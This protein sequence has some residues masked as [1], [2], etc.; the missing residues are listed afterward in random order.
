MKVITLIQRRPDITRA[1]FK[2]YYEKNHA[3]LGT[4]YFPFEKYVRN[5]L[6]S[7]VPDDVGFDVLMECW[8]DRATAV[9]S[10]TGDVGDIFN[11]DEARFMNAPPRPEG[12]DV[13]EHLVAGPPRGVDARGARKVA[14]F[15]AAGDELGHGDFLAAATNWGRQLAA[16]TGATRA[17]L[18]EA[19]PGHSAP[20]FTADAI[21]TL[22]LESDTP[23]DI[24]PPAGISVRAALALDSQETT[25]AELAAAFGSR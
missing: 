2:E 5:H 12:F 8:L 17:T 20:L 22:W 3:P 23:P 18:D 11:E 10:L 24:D 16:R 19:L 6:V 7:S 13:I 9:A 4:R 25:P 1:A 14:W 21:L 15:L